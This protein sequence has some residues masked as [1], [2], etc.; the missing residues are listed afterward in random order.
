MKCVSCGSEIM[1]SF[2]HAIIKNECPCCGGPIMDEEMMVLIEDVMRTILNEAAV[3]E[4]T[5]KKLAMTIVARYNLSMKDGAE[6]IVSQ[7][8]PMQQTSQRQQ[9]RAPM[10]SPQDNE[11]IKIAAPSAYQQIIAPEEEMSNNASILEMSRILG[12][13]ELSAA[14]RERILEEAVKEKYNMVD[15]TTIDSNF[16]DDGDMDDIPLIP[17]MQR[18]TNQVVDKKLS[19]A[20]SEA[21]TNPVL[22]QERLVRLARQQ[23]AL[24]S[25]GGSFRRSS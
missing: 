24:K 18:Q 5:A 20:L 15:Q 16:I 6:R 21:G 2:K 22:E 10:P 1:A 19:A 12:N 9:V 17:N 3:R 8:M 7:P 25:G 14:E 4:E 23:Q 13:Q 11:K